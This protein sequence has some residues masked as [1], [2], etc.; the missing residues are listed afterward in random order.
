[1][2]AKIGLLTSFEFVITITYMQI[3]TD[4]NHIRQR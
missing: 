2:A 4:Y 3:R 1:M